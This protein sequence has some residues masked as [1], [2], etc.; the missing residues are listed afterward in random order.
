MTSKKDFCVILIGFMSVPHARMSTSQIV[1]VYWCGRKR[2]SCF[3][4]SIKTATEPTI[5][6]KTWNSYVQIVIAKLRP[7]VVGTL[8]N[9][10]T[11]LHGKKKE[12]RSINQE[13]LPH[14]LTRT[15][16]P[17][18]ISALAWYAIY[19][20][21]DW[22]QV[23]HRPS[24]NSRLEIACQSASALCPHIQCLCWIPLH[25]RRRCPVVGIL[26]DI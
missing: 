25:L 19:R 13:V 4:S 1:M 24:W 14:C 16:S 2:K 15:L 26:C 6:S 20:G 8:R 17:K 21:F 9:A 7:F 5:V 3:N 11:Y 22:I 23:S 12:R 18:Y 10:R